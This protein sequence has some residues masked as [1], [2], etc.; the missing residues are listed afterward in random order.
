[1]VGPAL[2]AVGLFSMVA[3][4]L[5]RHHLASHRARVRALTVAGIATGGLALL[6]SLAG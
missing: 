1:M 2:L 6:V 5:A 3:A 4:T